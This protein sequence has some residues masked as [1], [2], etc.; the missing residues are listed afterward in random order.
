MHGNGLAQA[1]EISDNR[2]WLLLRTRRER[3]RRRRAAEKCDEFPSPH[4]V[5]PK[6][7]DHRLKYS[8]SHWL[9]GVQRNK[10]RCL[11]SG[12]G[13]SLHMDKREASAQCPLYPGGFN[14]SL[15][16]RS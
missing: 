15:Q 6:A 12:W 2:P 4:E 7:K 5:Y 3:P 8:R 14:W 11:M 9:S 1:A 13:Q 16:H 10:K